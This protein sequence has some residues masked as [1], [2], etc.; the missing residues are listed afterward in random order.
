[1]AK[2]VSAALSRVLMVSAR[3]GDGCRGS[4]GGYAPAARAGGGGRAV[5][6]E[7]HRES[8]RA[9]GARR[10]SEVFVLHRL[11]D[12]PCSWRSVTC[13]QTPMSMRIPASAERPIEPTLTEGK[14]ELAR[15]RMAQWKGSRRFALCRGDGAP[16]EKH[17]ADYHSQESRYAH[18]E[19]HVTAG[20]FA[21][22]A[23]ASPVL[24]IPAVSP[25]HI[26]ICD[27]SLPEI[28]R[29]RLLSMPQQ[30]QAAAMRSAPSET[31]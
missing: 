20:S 4:A 15:P 23:R 31:A 18:T 6:L 1:M 27:G 25:F 8:G 29:V 14:G 26:A 24:T 22:I 9:G 13:S 3:D 21:P 5:R 10:D 16:H 28:L 17:E 11:V 12:V 2:R 19:G 30:R 7:D